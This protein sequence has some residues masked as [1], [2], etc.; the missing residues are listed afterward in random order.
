MLQQELAAANGQIDNLTAQTEDMANQ[1]KQLMIEL[2]EL[3]SKQQLFTSRENELEKLKRELRELKSKKKTKN[4]SQ[5]WVYIKLTF[6][7]FSFTEW[8]NIG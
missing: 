2:S 6:N 7:Y 1:H 5:K 3:R 4:K 8:Q